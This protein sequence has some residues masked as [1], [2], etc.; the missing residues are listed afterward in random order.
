MSSINPSIQN[1]DSDGPR[2]GVDQILRAS[3]NAKFELRAE[4]S[5][6]EDDGTK[7]SSPPRQSTHRHGKIPVVSPPEGEAPRRESAQPGPGYELPGGKLL[8]FLF[9]L[10]FQLVEEVASHVLEQVF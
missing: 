9:C 8:L 7:N 3:A 1:P 2:G 6:E 4:N 10:T 5:N